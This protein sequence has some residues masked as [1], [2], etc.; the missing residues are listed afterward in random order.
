MDKEEK[1]ILENINNNI[2]LLVKISALNLGKELTLSEK[3]ILLYKVGLTPVEIANVLG[4]SNNATNARISE[5]RKK[6]N[7]TKL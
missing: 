7:K 5:F 3:I 6:Q 4:I 2:S 1:Q